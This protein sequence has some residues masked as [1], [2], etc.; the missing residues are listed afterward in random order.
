MAAPEKG[1]GLDM[2]PGQPGDTKTEHYCTQI[3]RIPPAFCAFRHACFL[4]LSYPHTLGVPRASKRRTE[5]V[6]R[7]YPDNTRQKRRDCPLKPPLLRGLCV[8]EIK[9]NTAFAGHDYAGNQGGDF[10]GEGVGFGGFQHDT[11]AGDTLRFGERGK[12]QGASVAE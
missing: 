1:K 10:G 8:K 2:P 5:F 7:R 9:R 11:L 4:S 3:E 12:I 6:R